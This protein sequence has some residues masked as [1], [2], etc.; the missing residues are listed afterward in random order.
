MKYARIDLYKTNYDLLPTCKL[1]IEPDTLLLDTIFRKYCRYKKFDSV[2]PLFEYQYKDINSDI[3]GYYNQEN[4][5][6]AFTL[7]RKLDRINVEN[8]QFAW[9]YENPELRLGI[10]SLKNECA[11]YKK[12]GYTYMY[13]GY[14]DEYKKQL[15]GFEILG[16]L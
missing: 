15:D 14:A 3:Y 10:E 11:I 6:I 13:L 12:L 1:I 16:P 5:L 2:M 7:I 8:C 4:N 9:D